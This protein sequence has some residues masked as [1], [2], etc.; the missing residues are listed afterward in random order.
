MRLDEREVGTDCVGNGEAGDTMA[1]VLLLLLKIL[2]L[3]LW[4]QLWLWLG[5]RWVLVMSLVN[6]LLMGV[7]ILLRHRS[8]GR[9]H[10]RLS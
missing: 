9:R 3:V 8:R 6:I 1:G 10:P 7:L 2:G 4:L 5:L